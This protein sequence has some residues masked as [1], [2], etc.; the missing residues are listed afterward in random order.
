MRFCRNISTDVLFSVTLSPNSKRDTLTPDEAMV[1]LQTAGYPRCDVINV[2]CSGTVSLCDS[3]L[4]WSNVCNTEVSTF[5]IYQTESLQ[6][7]GKDFAVLISLKNYS[8]SLINLT[9]S[10][11]TTINSIF[12][13]E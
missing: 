9:T 12:T 11:L 8:T 2:V 5:Y 3:R 13:V 7:V 6:Y 10:H 4:I 1:T